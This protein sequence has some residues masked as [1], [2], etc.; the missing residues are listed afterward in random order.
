MDIGSETDQI[1]DMDPHSARIR[2]EIRQLTIR[3]IDICSSRES[4]S[5]A[6]MLDA[7]SHRN[8]AINPQIASLCP[9]HGIM[10][11]P[12]EIDAPRPRKIDKEDIRFA[13]IA[14]SHRNRRSSAHRKEK[15]RASSK[16]HIPLLICAIII[17]AAI[18]DRR[19]C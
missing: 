3:P 15:Q 19:R 11:R 13:G 12:I 14:S 4:H 7:Q 17:Y 8:A 16:F 2:S 9:R 5:M 6:I 10:L 1:D 18:I